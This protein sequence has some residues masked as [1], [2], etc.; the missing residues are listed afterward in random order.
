MFKRTFL[1]YIHLI[2]YNKLKNIPLLYAVREKLRIFA[3]W[4]FVVSVLW[5]N[6]AVE[7]TTFLIYKIQSVMIA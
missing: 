6:M 3:T 2:N 5:A 7:T 4:V 1:F